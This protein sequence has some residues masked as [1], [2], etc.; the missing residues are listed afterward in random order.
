M[1]L[2]NYQCQLYSFWSLQV[3]WLLASWI[4]NA[5][6][7]GTLSTIKQNF[8][9]VRSLRMSMCSECHTNLAL[10]HCGQGAG[11]VPHS[12]GFKSSWGDCS[13]SSLQMHSSYMHLD[14]NSNS[15]WKQIFRFT[16]FEQ[17]PG[18]HRSSPTSTQ[19]ESLVNTDRAPRQ[20]RSSPSSTQIESLVNTDRIP[21]QHRSSPSSTQI[22]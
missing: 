1:K 6:N 20:H 4:G 11:L 21:H 7:Y 17:V 15:P 2:A 22:K 19:I 10:W 3:W 18:Q 8:D 12:P 9:R 5:S 16:H 13:L 14:N